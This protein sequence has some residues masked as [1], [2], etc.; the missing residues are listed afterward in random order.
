MNVFICPYFIHMSIHQ[1]VLSP[2][3][4]KSKTLTMNQDAHQYRILQ[5]YH[6]IIS[7]MIQNTVFVLISYT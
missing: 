4:K 1:K 7:F 3:L 6:E 5:R 2:S